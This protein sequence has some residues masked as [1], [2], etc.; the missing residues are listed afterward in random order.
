[1]TR[2]VLA[3]SDSNGP[4]LLRL[5]LGAVMFAHGAQKAFGWFGGAGLA[6]T[7]A[8]FEQGLGIPPA[9]TALAI[10]AELIGGI[11]LIIGAFGRFAALAI[12]IDMIVAV[13]VVHRA[14][15]FFMNWEGQKAGE[16]FEYHILAIAMAAALVVM[17]SGCCS[18]DRALTRRKERRV[19]VVTPATT[20]PLEPVGTVR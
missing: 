20:A 14:N 13:L 4:T 6:G 10:A 11:L 9:L 8:S 12:G 1:M 5:A 7:F 19:V 3:T 17:G 16:G 2:N 18:V 15:G